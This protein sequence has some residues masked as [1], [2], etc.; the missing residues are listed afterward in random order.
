MAEFSVNAD[1]IDPYKN[2]K[3]KLMWDGEY[4]AGISK[5]SALKRSTQVIKH[6]EGGDPG[7]TRKSIGQSD[8]EPITLERGVTHDEEFE[9][10]ASMVWSYP[11][12]DQFGESVKLASFRKD[13]VIEM[14]NVAGQKVL[15]YNVY[16]CWPSEY[17]A[18]PELDGSGNAIAIQSLTL[19]CEGWD[20]D[21]SVDEPDEPEDEDS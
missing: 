5:V 16:R 8:F 9:K 18:I 3:F 10:W 19:Q 20:R 1:R 12:S 4:I 14:Y 21:D 13:I 7:T 11:D 17:T 6:R 2:F 15:A